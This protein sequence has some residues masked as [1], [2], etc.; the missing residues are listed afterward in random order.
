MDKSLTGLGLQLLREPGKARPEW[1]P[2]QTGTPSSPVLTSYTAPASSPHP[3]P[4][5]PHQSEHLHA[6]CQGAR[7]KRQTTQNKHKVGKRGGGGSTQQD[8][9]L[10]LL[11]QGHAQLQN[12]QG[13][14]QAR[15]NILFSG[16]TRHDLE[17]FDPG[18]ALAQHCGWMQGHS[19]CA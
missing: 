2:P 17:G 19:L 3:F 1:R 9:L 12:V 10:Y 11:C 5:V 7:T 16:D 4:L 14:R 8:P 13:F 6:P 18:R 15:V